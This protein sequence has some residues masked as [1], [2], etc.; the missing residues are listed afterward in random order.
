MHSVWLNPISRIQ[1]LAFLVSLAYKNRQWDQKDN[2]WK[3]FCKGFFFFEMGNSGGQHLLSP[4]FF[5]SLKT[6]WCLDLQ[7]TCCG[8]KLNFM[9]NTKDGTGKRKR[10][11]SWK[12]YWAAEPATATSSLQTSCMRRIN[13]IS[14]PVSLYKL[15][16][17]LLSGRN[18]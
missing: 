8:H 7:Q 2:K 10:A 14:V 12:R 5:S 6:G 16:F 11:I 9:R 18:S 15:G 4:P 1:F 13:P 3:D 17:L